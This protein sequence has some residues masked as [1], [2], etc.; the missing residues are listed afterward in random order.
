MMS[1]NLYDIH[2]GHGIVL[3][4]LNDSILPIS[5]STEAAKKV[6]RI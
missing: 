3:K 4:H 2:G 5:F 6:S 1:G